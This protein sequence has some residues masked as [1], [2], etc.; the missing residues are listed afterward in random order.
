MKIIADR[1]TNWRLEVH[2]SECS[3]ELEL[4]RD[5][6]R[7][8]AATPADEADYPGYV[9]R[10]D[11]L[12]APIGGR[13]IAH[14]FDPVQDAV[15]AGAISQNVG[16][17][18]PTATIRTSID[19]RPLP[20]EPAPLMTPTA[21]DPGVSPPETMG[22]LAHVR[23]FPTRLVRLV[24]PKA[25]L[26]VLQKWEGTVTEVGD[27]WFTA[28]LRDVTEPG[29]PN[30]RIELPF[31]E[32]TPGDWPLV[33]AGAVFYWAIGYRD[34]LSGERERVSSIRFQRLPAWTRREV[35]DATRTAEELA[36]E[37]DWR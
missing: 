28:S 23:R 34:N 14:A 9:Y 5:G 13:M 32:V 10:D 25:H 35:R 26:R 36:R 22:D 2:C 12:A 16:I 30:E 1:A 31:E 11:D 8:A 21:S 15:D 37:L 24:P 6:V 33:A 20:P 4:S 7:C 18:P 3:S 19:R 29:R 27:G 17:E